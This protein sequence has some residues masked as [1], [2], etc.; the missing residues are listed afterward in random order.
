MP[1]PR[2]SSFTIIGLI[3]ILI[4]IYGLAHG[5]SFQYDL[6]VQAE[7]GEGYYYLIVGIVMIVNGFFALPPTKEE[8]QEQAKTAKKKA[9]LQTK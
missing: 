3:L 1:I 2:L 5:P 4:G 7:S 8:L 6:G 9:V